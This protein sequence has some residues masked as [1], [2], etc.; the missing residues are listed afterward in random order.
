MTPNYN[1]KTRRDG[2]IYA[3]PIVSKRVYRCRL[4]HPGEAEA[5]A[6][7][8]ALLSGRTRKDVGAEFGLSPF[9]LRALL[10]RF[11]LADAPVA[12]TAEKVG[13]A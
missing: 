6:I 10:L 5:A 8:A 13:A 12:A 2:S 4:H 3:Y 1:Y 11:P 9:R 7:Q